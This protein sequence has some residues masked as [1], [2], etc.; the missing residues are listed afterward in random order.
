MILMHLSFYWQI[1]L[2]LTLPNLTYKA[3]MIVINDI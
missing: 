1:T 2:S 3:I